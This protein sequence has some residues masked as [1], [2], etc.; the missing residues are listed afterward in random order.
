MSGECLLR[1]DDLDAAIPLRDLKV[2]GT[3]DFLKVECASLLCDSLKLRNFIFL[4]NLVQFVFHFAIGRVS[5]RVKIEN[6]NLASV[7]G[8]GLAFHRDFV[9][10]HLFLLRQG[11]DVGDDSI[12]G[13][14]VTVPETRLLGAWIETQIGLQVADIDGRHGPCKKVDGVDLHGTDLADLVAHWVIIF[15]TSSERLVSSF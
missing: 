2:T 14:Q 6:R 1:N 15:V 5:V 9:I 4:E 7:D 8:S 13:I 11:A 10:G 12:A 3:G